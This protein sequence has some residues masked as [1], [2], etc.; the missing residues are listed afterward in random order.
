M[1]LKVITASPIV[2][3]AR[4]TRLTLWICWLEV[5][6]V[7]KIIEI[8]KADN[9]LMILMREWWSFLIGSDFQWYRGS[10]W[11]KSL[12]VRK[13][14]RFLL[15]SVSSY[16]IFYVEVISLTCRRDQFWVLAGGFAFSIFLLLNF[17]D[18]ALLIDATLHFDV[19]TS[20][21]PF[22]WSCFQL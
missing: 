2:P 5:I 14:S 11:S 10:E 8:K 9:C 6:K 1:R 17:A 12:K 22:L 21:T 16:R 7:T 19:W 18:E 15:A 4:G 3:R 13:V 20:D